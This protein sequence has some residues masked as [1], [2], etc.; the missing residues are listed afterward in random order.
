VPNTAGKDARQIPAGKDARATMKTRFAFAGFRHVHILDLLTGAE[1]H[2]DIE[3]VACCEEDAAARDTLARQ[4]RVKITHTDFARMLREVPCDVIAIG[5]Y[6]AK[7]GSLVVAALEAGK[8][9]L[10]DKP[11]CTTLDEQTKIERLAEQRGRSVFLQLD[12]RTYGAFLTLRE[13]LRGGEIGEVT[14]M[15][16]DGQHPLLLGTRPGWYFEPGRHGGTI[17]DIAIHAFDFVPWMTGHGWRRIVA[18][19]TWNAKARDFPHFHDC[20]QFL[21]ELD[22]GAGVTADLS[23]LAPDKLGYTLPHYWRLTVHGTRGMAETFLLA[24][25]VTVITDA[26]A[27]PQQRPAAAPK[28]R[29]YLAD[30][31]HEIRAQ[32]ERAELRTTDCLRAS[33]LALEAEARAAK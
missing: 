5:D 16:I 24:K 31:L 12:S 26:D 29:Q 33:R 20:A 32:A 28:T 18:A 1:E 6:Y 13:I 17:N 30:F 23:Y 8:H 19:R 11:L 25:E 15:R 22:N 9:V 2:P 3:I 27:A 4:G 21:A 10:S 14:T 7:R